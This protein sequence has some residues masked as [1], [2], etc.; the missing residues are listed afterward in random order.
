M[1]IFYTNCSFDLDFIFFLER[2]RL[3][4]RKVIF[5]HDLK[6]HYNRIAFFQFKKINDSTEN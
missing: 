2:H 5:L 6:L 1:N 3:F 4:C